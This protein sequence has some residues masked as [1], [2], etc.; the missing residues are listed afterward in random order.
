MGLRVEVDEL[1]AAGTRMAQS[2]TAPVALGTHPLA[3][4]AGDQVSAT[5]AATVSARLHAIGA[6]SARAAYIKTSAAGVLHANAVTYREQEE[7][8][9]ASLRPGGEAA[10][11]VA[12]STAGIAS[13]V[14]TAVPPIP[15]SP[16]AGV[17][18]T[19]GKSIAVL[20]HGGTGPGPLLAAAATA[21]TH[22]TELQ[23][24]STSLRATRDRLTTVWQSVGGEAA[25][26]RIATLASWYDDHAQHAAAA[27]RACES[28]AAS[29]A[30]AR[31]AVPTPAIFEDLERR[32]D[33]ANR[34]N[35]AARGAYT[36][37]ITALQTQLAATHATAVT[38]Y[39]DYTTRAADLGADAPTPAPPTVQALDTPT[40][41]ED[42]E[43][44]P[45]PEPSGPTR[46]DIRRVLDKLPIG[47][48]NPK[49]REVRS[50]EDLQN[51]WEWA[52][53]DGTE[54]PNGYGD[55]SKGT[56]YRLPDGTIVGQRSVASSNGEPTLDFN[57]PGSGFTKVHVNPSTGGVP[58]LSAPSTHSVGPF[59]PPDSEWGTH[60]SPEEAAEGGGELG[61][62][63]KAIESYFPPDPHDPQNTA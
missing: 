9:A 50:P 1:H 18:P 36:Q 7:A 59:T 4:A 2:V 32:L 44:P 21:R 31:A 34:A 25:T 42:P 38:A 33:A 48:R 57:V 53:Q 35:V 14:P 15:A 55:P 47:N 62:L 27:A 16:P 30:Q 41:T 11:A 49:V 28:Q 58:D 17:V 5:V 26:A 52:T 54:I 51:L 12:A 46:A 56:M 37:V 10:G 61:N 63:G 45:P 20:M 39:A 23:Q 8:N 43:E 22:A 40:N 60:V 6:H 13:A 29:F 24:I 19:D 3:P